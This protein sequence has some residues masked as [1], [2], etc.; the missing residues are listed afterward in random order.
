MAASGRGAVVAAVVGNSV[1]TVIK[2]VAFAMSGSGSMFS[3]AMHS[4]ADTANQALLFAGIKS[5]ERP[6]DAMF[7][8]G[9]GRDR[10]FFSLMSAV[11]VFVLGCGVTLYHGVH[12]LLHPGEIGD[13]GI[14]VGVLIVSFFVDGFVLATA[15]RVVMREKGDKSLR[16]YLRTTSDPTVITVLLE[17]SIACIGVLVALAAIVLTK[18]TGNPIWDAL[19]TLTIAGMLGGI[20]VWLGLKNRHLLLGPA[21]Q[22]PIADD[23]EAFLRSRRAVKRVRDA[24]TRIIG[25]DKYGMTAELEFDGAY[26]GKRLTPFVA[27]H[28]GALGTAQAQEAFASEFGARL[29]DALGDEV[30]VIEGEFREKFPQL[31]YVDL[32]AD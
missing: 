25:A 31:R 24:K 29:L 19:G 8:Y 20:A 7:P 15:L 28:A 9:Y 17:D 11:G 32:E 3:E 21:I 2:F 12:M 23:V 16:E 26:L 14:S 6:A 30:D 22:G 5:S 27:E 4:M 10:Y 13:I 1:L 18:W